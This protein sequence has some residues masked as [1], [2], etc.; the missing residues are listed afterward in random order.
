M[1]VLSVVMAVIITAFVGISSSFA[2]SEGAVKSGSHGG[3][4][5]LRVLEKLD[6]SADQQHEIEMPWKRNEHGQAPI[7]KT[8]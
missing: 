2:G 7:S 1:K 3:R 5:F 6:L 4:G 8:I